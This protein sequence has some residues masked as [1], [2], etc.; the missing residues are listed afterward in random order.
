[1]GHRGAISVQDVNVDFCQGDWTI[2][3][4]SEREWSSLTQKE[5][6]NR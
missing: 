2:E 1:M 5:E 4:T 6:I 3:P